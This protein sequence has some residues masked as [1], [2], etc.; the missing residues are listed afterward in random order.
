MLAKEL[1]TFNTMFNDYNIYIDE[2]ENLDDIDLNFIVKT[3][4]KVFDKK[5]IQDLK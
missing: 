3:I 4:T 1:A 2:T 5:F